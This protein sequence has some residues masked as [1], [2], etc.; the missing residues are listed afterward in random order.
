MTKDRKSQVALH[1]VLAVGR[2]TSVPEAFRGV[3]V[4]HPVERLPREFDGLPKGRPGSH[5]LLAQ[6]SWE[7]CVTD[8]AN[9]GDAG[10]A[11]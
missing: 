8:A 4:V 1:D 10:K 7:A 6:D 3:S 11:G 2:L 5:Q 9:A